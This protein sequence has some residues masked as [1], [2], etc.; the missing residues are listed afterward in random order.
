MYKK[1]GAICPAFHIWELVILLA[2]TAAAAT[3]AS[4]TTAAATATI[5]H[6][7]ARATIA[8]AP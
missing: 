8:T 1:G 3:F 4:A 2:I 6:H 5:R 7:S